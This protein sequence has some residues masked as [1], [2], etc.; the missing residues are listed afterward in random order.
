MYVCSYIQF[1][2]DSDS[3]STFENKTVMVTRLDLHS[4]EKFCSWPC[5]ASVRKSFVCTVKTFVDS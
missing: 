3:E 5:N 4:V 2:K 1:V